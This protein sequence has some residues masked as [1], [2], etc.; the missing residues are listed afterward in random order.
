[1]DLLVYINHHFDNNYNDHTHDYK[2]NNASYDLEYKFTFDIDQKNIVN[3]DHDCKV[4]D[5]V[6]IVLNMNIH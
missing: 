3:C 5:R 4:S 1:M 6:L 2:G